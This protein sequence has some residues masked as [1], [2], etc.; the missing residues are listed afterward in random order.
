M[1]GN[2]AT[3]TI[4]NDT[5]VSISGATVVADGTVAALAKSNEQI[6]NYGGAVSVGATAGST[7]VALG[8]TI[9]TNTITGNTT[10][11]VNESNITALG[12]DTG[13]SI[14]DRT[15]TETTDEDGNTTHAVESKENKNKKGFVV[16][17]DANHAVNDISITAG[18]GASSAT[19]VAADATVVINTI[20]GKT[21]A[22]VSNSNINK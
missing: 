17:A 7:G 2:V 16:N 19:G 22:T 14:M 18:V 13:V 4:D 10:S 6:A 3:N 20:G 8:A 12:N 11:D 1:A 15:V 9:V 5:A 21:G